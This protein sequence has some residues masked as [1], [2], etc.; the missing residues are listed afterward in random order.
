MPCHSGRS[1]DGPAT[2]CCVTACSSRL[3]GGN[4][5]TEM[6][7]SERLLHAG[8]AHALTVSMSIDTERASEMNLLYN[9]IM[10]PV[11]IVDWLMD[12]AFPLREHRGSQF[13]GSC[14]PRPAHD[15]HGRGDTGRSD[16]V[17]LRTHIGGDSVRGDWGDKDRSDRVRC[18]GA[19]KALLG[20]VGTV[21]TLLYTFYVLARAEPGVSR[22][23][24]PFLF[25]MLCVIGCALYSAVGFLEFLFGWDFQELSE[26][27]EVFVPGERLLVVLFAVIAFVPAGALVCWL[28][29]HIKPS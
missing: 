6:P 15:R 3:R 12:K 28:A 16:R 17:R 7:A 13:S 9:I 20:I 18:R 25:G 21:A 4:T 24:D 10:A 8:R 27:W 11:E 5:V 29:Y 26:R 14:V 22:P 1:S 2:S 19:M 23:L